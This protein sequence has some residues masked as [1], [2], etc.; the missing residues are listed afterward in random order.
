MKSATR[1]SR[2]VA[3]QDLERRETFDLISADK[4]EGTAVY[5]RAGEKLGAIDKI[6]IDKISGRVPYAVMSF[7]G[8]LGMGESYHPLPWNV[9]DYDTNKGGY[10]VD[11]DPELLKGAPTLGRD[12]SDETVDW[13]DEAWNRR[14][15]DYYGVTPYWL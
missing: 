9:L 2:Q 12:E 8:F 7:G 1:T 5:N 6:M 3:A 4:V 10:V 13:R 15:H 11:L 14:L